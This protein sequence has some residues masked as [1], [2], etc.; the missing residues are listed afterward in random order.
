MPDSIRPIRFGWESAAVIL[1]ARQGPRTFLYV[2]KGATATVVG[3][4]VVG[5]LV[6]KRAKHVLQ[7]SCT[8]GQAVGSF[9]RATF[10][11]GTSIH[12]A[13]SCARRGSGFTPLKCFK[14][15]SFLVLSSLW[16]QRFFCVF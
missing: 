11:E 14:H 3:D 2:G 8:C 1:R 10:G 16:T 12:P 6:N 7:A 4:F 9:E 15:W 13:A 5:K